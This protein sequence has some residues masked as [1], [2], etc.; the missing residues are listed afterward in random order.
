ML[1]L[2]KHSYEICFANPIL[3]RQSRNYFT[4][5][6]LIHN[7][8]GQKRAALIIIDF[9]TIITIIDFDTK[10]PTR[11]FRFKIIFSNILMFVDKFFQ[12]CWF[13]RIGNN[14]RFNPTVPVCPT[15]EQ[16]SKN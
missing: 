14:Y 9:N 13:I 2:R 6:E 4:H 16:I 7:D 10:L 3:K 11:N 12:M 5:C 15:L 1:K 8:N